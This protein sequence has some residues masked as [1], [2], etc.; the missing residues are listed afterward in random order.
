M[1]AII[2]P[3]AQNKNMHE[4]SER[5][6]SALGYGWEIVGAAGGAI[7]GIVLADVLVEPSVE[8]P[9]DHSS[10]QNVSDTLSLGGLFFGGALIGA[11][12]LNRAKHFFQTRQ[13]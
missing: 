2:K 11:V 9:T 3:Q 6:E 13:S 1:L 7:G 12:A 5:R 10:E 8:Q 4:Q